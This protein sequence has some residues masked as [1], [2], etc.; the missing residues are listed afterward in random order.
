M[1]V[2]LEAADRVAAVKDEL[3]IVAH[4]GDCAVQVM[5]F[6]CSSP[7]EGGGAGVDRDGVVAGEDLR[8]GTR[9]NWS[10]PKRRG[11]MELCA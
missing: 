11:F 3:V 9:E 1:A 8:L 6:W 10:F 2:T 7:G 4:D 5:S